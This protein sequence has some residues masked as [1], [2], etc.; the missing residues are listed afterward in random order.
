[1][2]G[3]KVEKRDSD[4]TIREKGKGLSGLACL[5]VASFFMLALVFV[6]AQSFAAT[7]VKG[8][9]MDA[10]ETMAKLKTDL[11]L[12]ADQEGKIKP[13]VDDHFK[14]AQQI[15]QDVKAKKVTKE[16]Y[17]KDKKAQHDSYVAGISGVLTDEQ[18]GKFQK[19]QETEPSMF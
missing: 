7:A 16:Q 18:K 2:I 10:T 9:R 14:W 8:K 19:L 3:Q 12:T 13:L 5:A 4:R 1:M 11:A 15:A 17:A 6:S